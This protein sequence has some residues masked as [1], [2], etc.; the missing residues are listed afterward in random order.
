MNRLVLIG[1]GHAHLFVLERLA[2]VRLAHTEVLLVTPGRWQYYSGMIPGWMTGD[3]TLEECRIDLQALADAAGVCLIPEAMVGMDA[4]QG[5]IELSNGQ[6]VSYD[7]LSLDTGSE[8][9][10][11]WLAALD[12]RLILVKPLPDF[13]KAWRAMV[14]SALRKNRPRLVVVG[15]GAA[16]AELAMAANYRLRQMNDQSEVMLVTGEGGL[17]PNFGA[18]S[19][20]RLSHALLGAGVEIVQERAV[21]H[22]KG[23]LLES[24][25]IIHADWVIA[26]TGARA[27]AWLAGSQ[28]ELDPQG[29]I[30][31]DRYHRSTSHSRVFAAGDVCSRTDSVLGRSG[32][33]AVRVGPILGKNLIAALEGKPMKAYTPARRTLSLLTCGGRRAVGAWGR[34][35]VEGQWVWRWKDFIDRRFV[36]QFSGKAKS[37]VSDT[38]YCRGISWF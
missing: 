10:C 26:A 8:T 28:L 29:F 7:L 1:G 37:T 38:Q 21:G 12:E 23:L 16:G 25:K 33:H 22:E 19:R 15:G 30:V 4:S 36:R 17:L 2:Q 34:W 32:V 27:P 11:Q 6:Q 5:Y 31:V 18:E 13:L 24:G 9:D 14:E 20:R 35:G 3:Y